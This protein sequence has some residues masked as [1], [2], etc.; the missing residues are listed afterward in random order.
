MEVGNFYVQSNFRSHLLK[1]YLM[2]RPQ[3]VERFTEGNVQ[4]MVNLLVGGICERIP[5][6]TTGTNS[7]GIYEVISEKNP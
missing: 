5:E 3:T 7:K 1:N 2:C 6:K 4:A